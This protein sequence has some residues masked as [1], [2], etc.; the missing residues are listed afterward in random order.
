VKPA[1]FRYAAPASLDEAL[2]LLAQHGGEAKLLAGGQS[3]VP[4][5][6]LR[7]ARPAVLVDMRRL[8]ALDGWREARGA[9]EI[10]ALVRQR[11]LETDRA[12]AER[13]PL[14]A[15][16]ARW[17]GHVATRSRGAIVGSLC[18]ADPAAELPACAV[19]L[20]AELR[21]RSAKGTRRIAARD[22]FLDAMTTKLAEDELVESA[23]FPTW[24]GRSGFACMEV[25][26]RHG[27]VALVAVACALRLDERG[28]VAQAGLALGGIART[29]LR[30]P[31]Q[32]APRRPPCR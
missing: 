25:A 17:I 22:F 30:R 10:D 3:L 32:P 18:H 27:D 5:L 1:P 20:G 21:I 31:S 6:N 2:G 7:L 4:L 15:E 13:L 16:A 28:R 8:P 12:L 26:R 19:A 11:K 29:P 9:V 24:S 14:L 23:A